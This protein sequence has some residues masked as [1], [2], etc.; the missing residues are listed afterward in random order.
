[1]AGEFELGSDEWMA[2]YLLK[3]LA[4]DYE[5]LAKAVSY[6]N[7]E[8]TILDLGLGT[9]VESY[10]QMVQMARLN[11]GEQIANA[12]IT[13]C[14]FT[15]F[16]T[17]ATD[18]D[19]G[20]AEAG[21]IAK[22]NRLLSQYPRLAESKAL[23]GRGY[24]TVLEPGD[25]AEPDEPATLA[26]TDAW[27]T[28]SLQDATRP[29]ITRAAVTIGWNAE[30][31]TDTVMLFRV[32]ATPTDPG[33]MRVISRFDEGGKSLFPAPGID[34]STFSVNLADPA[35]VWGPVIK[36]E[37]IIGSGVVMFAT[38]DGFG[39]YE[40]HY[41]TL[42]RINTGILNRLII[43]VMQAFKQR[44]VENG[45]LDAT[46]PEG[47]P[48]AGEAI[49]L[50]EMFKSGP[51]ALWMLPEGAKMW[52]S[53]V[54]DV[55]PLVEAE[56]ADLRSLASATATPLYVLDPTAAAGGGSASGA[57]LA[58]EQHI[59]AVNAWRDD[60]GDGLAQVLSFAFQVAGDE[61][62]AQVEDI[63]VMWLETSVVTPEA[64]GSAAKMMRDAGFSKTYIGEKVLGMAPAELRRE[65]EA[66]QVESFAGGG[67]P[68]RP[69]GG[70]VG[71]GMPPRAGGAVA[72][73]R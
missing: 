3:G 29:W 60:D 15:G 22:R 69:A 50:D 23:Y 13:K 37:N 45:V 34:A 38:R 31:S 57:D 67:V 14:R 28:F 33:Y 73:G 58:R 25:D 17:A 46:Y 55:T 39:V 16:R 51:D 41:D 63:T 61:T 12:L 66:S 2:D 48:K 40:K 10:P 47:H 59:T 53:T 6:R 49:D 56:K 19:D 70:S 24:V 8:N 68:S 1:M 72:G 54:V 36:Y 32:G 64:K 11:M 35:W 18:D 26:V 30:T 27:R 62:R 9:A 71:S 44:A 20:D 4:G 43:T 7:G 65:R 52:E 21:R 5:R 42:D